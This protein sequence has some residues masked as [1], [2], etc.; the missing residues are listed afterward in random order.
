MVSDAKTLRRGFRIEWCV[1]R[2]KAR[3]HLPQHGFQHVVAADAQMIS[4]DLQVGMAV[5]DMPGETKHVGGTPTFN[6]DQ[7]L[8]R[9][10][11]FNNGA[12]IEHETIA[13][14]QPDRPLQ[15][16]HKCRAVLSGQHYAPALALISAK[17]NA[18]NCLAHVPKAC[19]FD[20]DPATHA[21]PLI[22]EACP[23]ARAETPT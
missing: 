1:D 6:F 9:P 5:A 16:E 23:T 2:R 13:I 10:S 4:N 18:I 22:L 11:H 17:N 12:V 8:K 3:S 20:C 15:V 14:T 21:T 19:R 7:R